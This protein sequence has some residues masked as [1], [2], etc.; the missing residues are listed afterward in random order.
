MHKIET[1]GVQHENSV[2]GNKLPAICEVLTV[3]MRCAEPERVV[4]ALNFL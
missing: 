4:A 1:H 3:Y 2:F